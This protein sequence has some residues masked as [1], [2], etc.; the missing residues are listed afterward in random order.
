MQPTLAQPADLINILIPD[1][2]IAHTPEAA[3][4]AAG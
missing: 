1:I 4:I 3:I 2:V